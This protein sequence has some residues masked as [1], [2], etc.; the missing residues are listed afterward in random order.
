MTTGYLPSALDVVHDLGGVVEGLILRGGDAVLL[1]Q[2]LGEDLAGLD[3]GRGLVRAEGRDADL[4]QRVHHAQCQR[5]V[6]RHH[7]VVE[8]FLSAKPT[9]VSTSVALMLTQWAS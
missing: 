6:L 5:V 3:A 7:D 9:I 2:V 8:L 4:C 1:H